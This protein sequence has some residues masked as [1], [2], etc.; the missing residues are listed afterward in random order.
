MAACNKCSHQVYKRSLICKMGYEFDHFIL[1]GHRWWCHV[2]DDTYV[3]VVELVKLL[4]TY[5][6]TEDWYLGRPS[7]DHPIE[8]IDHLHR[9]QKLA[10]WF[11]T[12]GAGFCI[13][14]ALALKMVP[15]AGTSI[16]CKIN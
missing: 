6:H 3:N 4:G 5:K 8:V 11:A 7:L 2:D 10:F 16:V 9:G 13:S 12:G 1:S 15:Y 14:R